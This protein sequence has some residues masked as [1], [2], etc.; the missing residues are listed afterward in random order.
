MISLL[1]I[2]LC[3]AGLWLEQ[4]GETPRAGRMAVAELVECGVNGKHS[5]RT[6]F[7]IQFCLQNNSSQATV[8]RV[9][10]KFVALQCDLGDCRE[11]QAVSKELACDLAPSERITL[12]ENINFKMV[13][14]LDENVVWSV[15]PTSVKAVF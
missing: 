15:Q 10:L 5:Y 14:P 6:N 9:A 7:D 13:D 11:V 1:A 3:A 8:K 4:R 2:A 12:T